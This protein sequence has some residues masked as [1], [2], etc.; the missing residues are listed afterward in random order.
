MCSREGRTRQ[1]E[2]SDGDIKGMREEETR[3][4]GS[5]TGNMGSDYNKVN[6]FSVAVGNKF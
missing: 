4:K 5:D 6:F 3:K 2:G 1:D